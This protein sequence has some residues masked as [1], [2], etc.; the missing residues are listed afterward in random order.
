MV[1][2]WQ[3]YRQEDRLSYMPHAALKNLREISS[4]MVGNCCY[5]CHISKPTD[6]LQISNCCRL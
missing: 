3:G 1:K 6:F 2:I 5:Y 4:M